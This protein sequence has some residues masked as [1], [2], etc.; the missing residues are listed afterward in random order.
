MTFLPST[1]F[2][3]R[4]PLD[5][6]DESQLDM[7]VNHKGEKKVANDSKFFQILTDCP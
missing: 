3:Y 1:M 2:L 6:V 7:R 4:K 5:K